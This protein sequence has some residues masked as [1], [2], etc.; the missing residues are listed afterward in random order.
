MGGQSGLSELSVISWVSAFEG[1]LLSGV[2]L[3]VRAHMCACEGVCVC[4]CTCMRTVHNY[5]H[6]LV[7]WGLGEVNGNIMGG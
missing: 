3:Y 1:C 4:T 6:E 5:V 7:V 2:P